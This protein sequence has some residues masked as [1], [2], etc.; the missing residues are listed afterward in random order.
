MR[1]NSD[2]SERPIT[3]DLFSG[4]GGISVGHKRA[5]GRDPD[6]AAN[7]DEIALGVHARNHPMTT[8]LLGD[9]WHRRPHHVAR[10]RRVGHVH[11]SPTCIDFSRAKGAPL[12]HAE[13]TKIRALAWVVRPWLREAPPD[14]LTMENVV[15]W[16]GWCRLDNDGK[17]I[18]AEKGRTFK[19][20]V[21]MIRSFG[22]SVDW[23]ALSAHYYGDATT[24]RRLFLIARRDGRPI[25]WPEPTHGPGTGKPFRS[26]AECIDFD[27]PCPSIFDED[28]G[29]KAPTLARIARAVRKHVL[30]AEEP[31]VVGGHAWAMIH[32]SNGE[33]PGQAPRIYDIRE[34]LGTVV[35][36]G[37]KHGLVAVC[38]VK[39]YGG[40][41]GSGLDV[42]EPL[43]AVTTRDHHALV[44]C[45]LHT[46]R[47]RA[48]RELL[49]RHEPDERQGQLFGKDPWKVYV[50]GEAYEIADIGMRSL[51][52]RERARS[53]SFPEDFVLDRDANG[54]EV[55]PT[56]QGKL[57]GN[58][59]P[60]MMAAAVIGANRTALEV[61]AA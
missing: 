16:E 58:S 54:D 4:C 14:V 41:E 8:H 24:R 49:S 11:A 3:V 55:S 1:T 51:T 46:D 2:A 12:E 6:Y 32:R 25:R 44:A 36:G 15:E 47:R 5:T 13:A 38:L 7:H 48:V 61:A 57:V 23:R 53:H 10:G 20:F 18:E 59:V 19:R 52:P 39:H 26:A 9:V 45:S 60:T 27:L 22:Y 43:G 31:F 17:R 30:D 35:A 21:R 28:R 56:K 37:N 34:P 40:H 29:L 50:G 42:R 33:R